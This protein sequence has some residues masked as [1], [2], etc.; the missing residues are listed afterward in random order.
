MICAGPRDGGSGPST[1]LPKKRFL[2][3]ESPAFARGLEAVNG[4]K[5][6]ASE[7]LDD[8]GIIEGEVKP[9]GW[10]GEVVA[11]SPVGGQVAAGHAERGDGEEEFGSGAGFE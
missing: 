3:G 8:R 2:E 11:L 1:V 10:E 7:A 6:E 4:A 5:D 9:F